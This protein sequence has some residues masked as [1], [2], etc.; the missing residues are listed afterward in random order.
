MAN[1][2]L[3]IGYGETLIESVKLT[4]GGGEKRYPYDFDEARGR[5]ARQIRSVVKAVEKIPT[6][7]KPKGEAVVEMTLH[8]AFLAK[9]Y[10]PQQLL[11]EFGLRHVGSKGRF[12]HPE[13]SLRKQAPP[14]GEAAPVLFVAGSV[15]NFAAMETGLKSKSLPAVFQNDFRK[16]ET[17]DVYSAQRKIKWIGEGASLASL[18]VVLHA[19]HHQS[20]IHDAFVQWAEEF[21]GEVYIDK[22]V[23]VPG[24]T[25]LP[26]KIG[27]D[28]VSA[29]AEFSFVRALRSLAPLRVHRPVVVRNVKGGDAVVLPSEG[30][31]DPAL[32]V[33]V[34]DGGIGHGDLSRWVDEYTWPD[35]KVTASNLLLH[36]NAVTT[37]VLFG[38]GSAKTTLERPFSR[39]RHYRVLG[40]DNGG[41][42]D[43]FDVLKKI[44][45]VLINEQPQFMNLS[46]GPCLPIEDD[47]VHVWTTL[48]DH[49][50]SNGRTFTT[51]AVGNDGEDPDPSLSRVQP[52]SDMVN[53]LGVGA[54]DSAGDTWH[55]APYSCIGPGRS[56][57]LMK[58]DGVAFGGSKSEAFHAYSPIHNGMV[59]LEGTSF[60]AP[61]VLRSAIGVA[62]SLDAPLS[63]TALR[64][65]IVHRALPHPTAGGREIGWGRFE[66]DP[67]KLI[68][69]SDNE[70]MVIYT[71][72]I[73]PGQPVRA[74]IPFPDIPLNGKVT[75]KATFA[76]TAPTDPAH[77]LNYTKAGLTVIFRPNGAK[78]A[79]VP[80]FNQDKFDSESDL[81]RDA[82]KWESCLSRSR[83]F[84]PG[85]L[86]EPVFDIEYLT[87]EEGRAVPAKEQTPLPYVLVVTVSV[88]NTA[89]VYNSVLQKYKSLQPVKIATQVHIKT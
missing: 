11:N 56:P 6:G 83:R 12:V 33:A 35:T 75:V 22:A 34:F 74:K 63:A 84:N 68:V 38:E 77:S 29:V 58:P 88:A 69:C 9:S 73:N 8:P 32:S 82:Q 20:Y 42:P 60:S 25:F 26:I 85:T 76:F 66:T 80:F 40:K 54:A 41:D 72:S 55:R 18:E 87:R 16:I 14:E 19:S 78:K 7:A 23:F 79:T 61:L 28:Q 86:D 59:G 24:L 1:K 49:R 21:G 37:T 17:L 62:A 3:L 70:A 2:N 47:D 50:L 45:W 81:R 36:G 43:L 4:R 5:I 48:L 15:E 39:V 71:G 89:G 46:L 57:G 51:V 67:E 27:R 13:V 53:A 52:P 30:A 64:A 44:D 65:L 10:F 31:V